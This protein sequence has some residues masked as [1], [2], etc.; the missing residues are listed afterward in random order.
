[1]TRKLVKHFSLFSY[2]ERLDT[3]AVERSHYGDFTHK[4]AE[5][6]TRLKHPEINVI[7]FACAVTVTECRRP[8]ES[9]KGRRLVEA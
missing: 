6:A 7:E 8:L 2:V 9:Q 3:G 5:L 1:M 4:T